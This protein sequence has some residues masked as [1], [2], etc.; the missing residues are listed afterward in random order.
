LS[1]FSLSL[2]LSLSVSLSVSVSL[3]HTH[4]PH[5]THTT[6]IPHTH[7]PTLHTHTHTHTGAHTHMHAHTLLPS[8]FL[9]YLQV[10]TCKNWVPLI[11]TWIWHIPSKGSSMEG[12]APLP[13]TSVMEKQL[14]RP[15]GSE[16]THRWI[17]PWISILMSSLGSGGS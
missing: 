11:I 1:L 16:L 9:S 10:Y 4:T 13:A 5:N 6:C 15:Q 17:H 3:I 7:T 14:I 8:V 2:S 12:F